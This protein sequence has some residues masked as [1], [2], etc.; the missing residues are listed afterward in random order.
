MD[1]VSVILESMDL[2][3][4]RKYESSDPYEMFSENGDTFLEE[5]LS[6]A[7]KDANK[8]NV[9]Q[10][11]WDFIKKVCK[12]ISKQ[13]SRFIS[14]IKGFFKK[15]SKSADQ[16]AEEVVPS[17]KRNV[18]TGAAMAAA[19]AV[20]AGAAVA[21]KNKSS[22]PSSV[23]VQTVESTSIPSNPSSSISPPSLDDIVKNLICAF[24]DDKNTVKFS[25]NQIQENGKGAK[26]KGKG[27]V[28]GMNDV[29]EVYMM[30][31][32]PD[33]MSE[34]LACLDNIKTREL[35]N[36]NFSAKY[37]S[38]VNNYNNYRRSISSMA[39]S[40]F[41]IKLD[42]LDRFNK[43]FIEINKVLEIID[44]PEI[45]DQKGM[46]MGVTAKPYD[47]S[48]VIRNLN[49]IAGL[50]ARWQMG[51]SGIVGCL[52][53]V[54][55]IDSSFNNTIDDIETLS[56]FV[57]K[58][59]D[60]GIPGKYIM[61]NGY[62]ISSPKLKGSGKNGSETSPIW[63]QSRFVF[64]PDDN[65][66]VMYKVAYNPWGL[67]ANKSETMVTDKVKE[68]GYTEDIIAKVVSHTQNDHVISIERA[69]NQDTPS[70]S[71]ISNVKDKLENFCR[72]QKLPI[73]LIADI[74][75]GNVRKINGKWVAIDYGD[76]ER[77][78]AV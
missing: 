44:S 26:I 36:N 10:K 2:D 77:S 72:S 29:V 11:I 56:Q 37:Q 22:D 24:E 20:A 69:D 14:F 57:Q 40:D 65:P 50:V 4:L 51:I 12:W 75:T 31:N 59:M 61:W 62:K 30:I 41:S 17:N 52:K 66:Q 8:K 48:S 35:A 27:L 73:S 32:N 74:H 1:L 78:Y 28:R 6:E 76:V 43:Q 16:I 21:N 5:A 34:F 63:G 39:Q 67:R 55:Q 64:F 47:S 3:P 33:L 60:S 7:G 13:L 42:V 19:G 46:N 23:S 25:W 9:I 71:V 18:I 54:Y 53:S 70:I 15:K 49:D 45:V 38:F 68:T 58:C